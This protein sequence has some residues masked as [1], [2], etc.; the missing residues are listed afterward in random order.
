MGRL[1]GLAVVPASCVLAPAGRIGKN[2]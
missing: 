2:T 1:L